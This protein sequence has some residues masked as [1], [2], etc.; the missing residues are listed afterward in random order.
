MQ[1]PREPFRRQVSNSLQAAVLF[2]QMCGARHDSQRTLA[3]E[4][5]IRLFVEGDNLFVV[6]PDNKQRGRF[7]LS[8]RI[9]GQVRTAAARDDGANRVPQLSGSNQRCRRPCA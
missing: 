9:T 8:Q 7:H 5:I 1:V 4:Q 3:V 6:A 2:E